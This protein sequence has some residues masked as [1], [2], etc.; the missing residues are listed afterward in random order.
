V[1]EA[2]VADLLQIEGLTEEKVVEMKSM[3]EKEIEEADIEEDEMQGLVV[4]PTDQPP[5]AKPEGDAPAP[6]EDETKGEGS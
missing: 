1:L 4:S 2:P 6:Q 3:M 5:A